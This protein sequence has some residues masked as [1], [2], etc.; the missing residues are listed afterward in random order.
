MNI[1]KLKAFLTGVQEFRLSITTNFEDE[2]GNDPFGL[3]HAYEHGRNFAHAV[4]FNM[5]R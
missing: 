2:D 5:Y 4:T 1:A 3:Q